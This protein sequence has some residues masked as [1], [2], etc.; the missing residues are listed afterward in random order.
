MRVIV[1]SINADDYAKKDIN[2]DYRRIRNIFC[3]KYF[4]LLF[5]CRVNMG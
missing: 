2:F 3:E 4:Y 5:L 1:F